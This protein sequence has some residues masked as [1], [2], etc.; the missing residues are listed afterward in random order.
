[1]RLP[2]SLPVIGA[3]AVVLSV[4]GCSTGPASD[5]YAG[6]PHSADSTPGSVTYSSAD[7]PLVE[8]ID[9]GTSFAVTKWGSG[10]CPDRAESVE[11][12]SAHSLIVTF[13]RDGADECTADDSPF[14]HEF[15]VPA[16]ATERPLTVTVR[17]PKFPEGY[18]ESTRTLE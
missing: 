5:S 13:S 9:G 2:R 17:S 16:G 7:S 6:G 11:V 12:T 10:S 1:M 18:W 4:A 8:W 14:T 15:A 3:I